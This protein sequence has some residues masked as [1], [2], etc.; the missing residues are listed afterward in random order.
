MSLTAALLVIDVQRAIDHPSWGRRNNPQAERN[1]ERLLDAWRRTGRP[2]VHVRHLSREP[3]STYRPGQDGIEFKNEALPR[4]GEEIVTKHEHSAFV[5]TGLEAWLRS[6]GIGA[7]VIAG[8]I[9]NNS[10]EA[11][12][13]MAADL[14]FETCVVS[15]ATATFD[16]RDFTGTPRSAEEVHAMSLA[17]LEGEYASVNDTDSVL[18]AL[19]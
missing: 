8:V 3:G 9:T 2:I 7:L 16:K 13:R 10:V 18:A 11:T 4:P 6:R 17:N 14:G 15:D 12:A 1:I 5:G 19:Q